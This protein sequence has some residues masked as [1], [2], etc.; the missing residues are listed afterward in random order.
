MKPIASILG[1]CMVNLDNSWA[2]F[3]VSYY[4]GDDFRMSFSRLGELR[5]TLPSVVPILALTA[6]STKST[7]NC[8]VKK[9]A[10]ENV[11]VI[12]MNPTRDNIHLSVIPNIILSEFITPIAKSL[13]DQGLSFPKSIIY[14]RTYP[15]CNAV[16]DELVHSLGSH[17]TH[18][19]GYPKIFKYLMVDF[20]TRGSTD[21]T[22]Q[23]VL[24]EFV[25]VGSHLRLIVATT[26]FGLGINCPD[27]RHVYHWGCPYTIE[28]YVQESGR[29]GRDRE[30]CRATLAYRNLRNIASNSP[31][32]HAYA[33]NTTTC[34]RQI[35]YKSFL[36]Y[37]ETDA[38]IHSCKCCDICTSICKCDLCT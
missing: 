37:T 20:Y 1:K 18:P 27:V 21:K 32:M 19:P 33:T 17:I 16:F 2:M 34:R 3:T 26:A 13:K 31:D 38:F 4:R 15:D 10:M 23:N 11:A 35:L 14:C 6:T 28:E 29:A 22:K 5:S 30:P 36:F 25:K 8:I 9:L 7:Y 12:G 24:D